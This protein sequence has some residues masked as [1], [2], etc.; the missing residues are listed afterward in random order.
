MVTGRGRLV[1]RFGCAV[2]GT[3]HFEIARRPGLY[4]GW[5]SGRIERI[6]PRYLLEE[7]S[8]ICSAGATLRLTITTFSSK[9]VTFIA[10]IDEAIIELRAKTIGSNAANG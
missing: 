9:W 3:F 1:P 8:L 10:P 4:E 2:G 7:M 6:E 5:F